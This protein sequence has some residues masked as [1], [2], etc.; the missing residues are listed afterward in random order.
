LENKITTEYNE[1]CLF[2]KTISID[3]NVLTAKYIES[4]SAEERQNL[5]EP[6]FQYFRRTGFIFPDDSSKLKKERLDCFYLVKH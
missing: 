4:L 3:G 5:I 1:N 2:D 6:V